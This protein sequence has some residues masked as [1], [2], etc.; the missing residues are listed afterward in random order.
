MAIS[1]HID[2]DTLPGTC[3]ARRILIVE[4]E[5]IVAFDL[6]IVL[7]DLGYA[8]VGT[9]TSSDEALRV[10]DAQYPDLVL[11][12]I[13]IAVSLPRFRG[14]L[15]SLSRHDGGVHESQGYEAQAASVYARVQV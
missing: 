13:N 7:E 5:C 12:D 15:P 9:A 6:T 11:M 3:Q 10:A 14:D 8:V 4:D 2:P 1:A